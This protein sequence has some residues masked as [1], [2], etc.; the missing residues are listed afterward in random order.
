[1]KEKTV[2]DCCEADT[3]GCCSGASRRDLER[4]EELLVL[5]DKAKHTNY[6]VNSS[7]DLYIV[8]WAHSELSFVRYSKERGNKSCRVGWVSCLQSQTELFWS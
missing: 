5:S 3:S 1:M 4:L 6:V 8:T 7:F 2:I